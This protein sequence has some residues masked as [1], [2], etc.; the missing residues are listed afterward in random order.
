MPV[1]HPE[2]SAAESKDLAIEH[3]LRHDIPHIKKHVPA[4]AGAFRIV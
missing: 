4:F 2:Q 3:N 1:C